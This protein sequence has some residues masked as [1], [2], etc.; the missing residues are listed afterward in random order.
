MPPVRQ[1]LRSRL[2]PPK[3]S[4]QSAR[5][6]TKPQ[7]KAEQSKPRAKNREAAPAGRTTSK[8]APPKQRTAPS[9]KNDF[10]SETAISCST[11]VQPL[12]SDEP[13]KEANQAVVRLSG[14]LGRPFPPSIVPR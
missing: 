11:I 4:S 2:K 3:K 10:P 9:P 8:T 7:P 1:E 12:A 14:Q 6:A 5:T 13:P